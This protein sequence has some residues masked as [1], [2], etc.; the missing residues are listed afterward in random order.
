MMGPEVIGII[1]ASILGSTVLNTVVTR[2]FRKNNDTAEAGKTKA[3]AS[4]ILAKAAETTLHI[5][6]TTI[7]SQDDRIRAQDLR[8]Q[9]LEDRVLELHSELLEYKKVHGPLSTGDSIHITGDIT[10]VVE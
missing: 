4:D 7:Q 10:G 2:Y 6:Q 1:I 5:M 9:R 3:E 8:I